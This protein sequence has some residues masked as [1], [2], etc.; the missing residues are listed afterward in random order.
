MIPAAVVLGLGRR[1]GRE[2]ASRA[3]SARPILGD[4]QSKRSS[5]NLPPV[6]LLDRLRRMPFL[7]KPH[8]REASGPARLAVLGNVN[9][10]HFP[11][12]AEE[13]SKLLIGR[14]E[15]EVAYKY[16]TRNDCSPFLRWA[17]RARLGLGSSATL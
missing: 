3:L 14:G 5:S 6:E 1:R 12:L 8:E 17:G 15:V 2:I 13:L 7:G 10:H 9:V 4:I 11:D 16:L